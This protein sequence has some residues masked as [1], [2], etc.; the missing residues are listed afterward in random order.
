MAINLF[1]HN[2]K[3]WINAIEEAY[4]QDSVLKKSKNQKALIELVKEKAPIAS[5]SVDDQAN[6]ACR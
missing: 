4:K 6:A 5:L 1:R 2:P 3:L